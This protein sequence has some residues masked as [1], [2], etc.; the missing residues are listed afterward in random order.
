MTRLERRERAMLALARKNGKSA[1]GV[2][3]TG[4]SAHKKGLKPNTNP[5]LDFAE[6]EALPYTAPEQHHHISPSRNFPVNV[7]A[8]LAEN[9]GDP[10]VTVSNKYR[11]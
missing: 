11:S 5:R 10:A 4:G 3:N 2:S 6:S 1:G 9:R 7:T 8:F